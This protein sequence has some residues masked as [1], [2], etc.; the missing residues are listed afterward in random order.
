[1]LLKEG[2]EIGSVFKPERVADFGDVPITVSEQRLGLL[3]DPLCNPL[4]GRAACLL[5]QQSVEVIGVN[6]QLPGKI[7]CSSELNRLTRQ[8]NGE[9]PFKQVGKKG[10]YAFVGIGRSVKPIRRIQFQ[11]FVHDKLHIV[12]KDFIFS[13]ISGCL[14][15]MHPLKKGG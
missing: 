12:A 4:A 9:L 10:K 5:P 15:D 7:I 6:I 1:M 2:M 3:N 14:F 11:C 8:I 13:R